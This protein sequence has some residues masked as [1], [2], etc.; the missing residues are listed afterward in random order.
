MIIRMRH[1]IF[2]MFLCVA[3][4]FSWSIYTYFFDKTL[5]EIMVKGLVNEQYCSGDTYC[6]IMSNK[7]GYVCIY[8]D[9]KPLNNKFKIV[10]HDE[11]SFTIPTKTIAPGKHYLKIDFCDS[12]YRKNKSNMDL[13]FYVDNVSLQAAFVNADP[14]YKV[15]QGRTLHVQFQVNKEIKQANLTAFSKNYAC[16]PEAKGSFIYECFVPTSCEEQP[17]EYQFE[18][19]IVDKVGNYCNLENRFQVVAYPFKHETLV[20]SPEKIKEEEALGLDSQK[21]E[22]EIQQ[23]TD[24]SPCEKLWRGPFCK[25][26]D[27]VRVTCDFGTVRTTRHK[28]RYSHKAL[29]VIND[30]KSVIWATQDGIIVMKKRFALSGNTIIIDH[31]WGILS[32]FYHLDDFAPHIEVGNHIR[33]GNPI[34]YIGKTGY[35]KGYHLHWEMRV[36]NVAIDPMQWTKPTF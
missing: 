13:I 15:F 8:L 18:V 14:D 16:F 11:C 22:E 21:L 36:Y 3:M 17:N 26:I 31:G 2:I 34:G 9:G 25:P 29:D 1:G 4:W 12:S 10:K 6:T 27:I 20:I 28:G 30:P 5:P 24:A 33:K 23:L 32:L 19:N 7:S 35:A